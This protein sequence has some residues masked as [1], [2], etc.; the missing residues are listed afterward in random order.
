MGY[1]LDED[2][3][4]KFMWLSGVNDFQ[5]S[6]VEE[7]RSH[8]FSYHEMPVDCFNNSGAVA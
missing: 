8:S 4:V 7:T 3:E 2:V 1:D 5:P 6:P